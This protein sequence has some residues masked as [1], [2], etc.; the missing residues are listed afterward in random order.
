MDTPAQRSSSARRVPALLGAVALVLL[1]SPPLPDSGS[2]RDDVARASERIAPSIDEASESLARLP[3][4]F[5]QNRGQWNDAVTFRAVHGPMTSWFGGNGWTVSLTE[6]VAGTSGEDARGVAVRMAFENGSARPPS[7]LARRLEQQSFH[8]ASGSVANAATYDRLQYQDM[9]PGVDVVVRTQDGHLE[10]DVC[11]QPGAELDDVIVRC[12]GAE[13]LSVGEDGALL[14]Q[15]ALGP[16]RSEPPLTWETLPDGE[17]R[18]LAANY[19]RLDEERFGF[20]VPGWDASLPLVI[21]P[22]LSWATYLGSSS[23]DFVQAVACD[24]NGNVVVAGYT[25]N[26]SFPSTVGVFDATHNGSRD[27]FISCLTADGTTLLAST[28]LGGNKDEEARAVALD[29]SGGVVVAGWTNSVNY[30]SS[31]GA[32]ASTYAGGLGTLRSDAFVSRLDASLST[33]VFSTYLGSE[34][35]DFASAVAVDEDDTVLVAGKTSSP[36]WPTTVGAY[37]RTYNGG[38]IEVGDSFV[39]RLSPDGGTMLWSTLLGGGI[40]EYAQAMSIAPDGAVTL[41]GWTSSADFPTTAG[42]LGPSLSGTSDGFVA[43]LSSDGSSLLRATFLGGSFDE[44]ATAMQIESDGTINVA[45]TTLSPNFPVTVDAVQSAYAGG[46]FYGDGFVA[47]LDDALTT[48][49]WASFLGGSSDDFL[50]GLRVH[51]SGAILLSGWTNSSDLPVSNDADDNTL[52]GTTDAFVACLEPSTSSLVFSTYIGGPAPDKAHAVGLAING[53]VLLGGGTSSS[54]FPVTTGSYD[55]DFSGWE[56]I[57]SDAFVASFDLG[58]TPAGSIDAWQDVGY[59]LAGTAGKLPEFT[60]T[61]DLTPLSVGVATVADCLPNQPALVMVGTVAAMVPV[62][63]GTLVPFP[64][65]GI[66]A[67]TTDGV[68]GITMPYQWPGYVPSGTTLYAQTWVLD[69]AGPEGWAATN[70]LEAVSP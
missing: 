37:D 56:G 12:E 3:S 34:R 51:D 5:V 7:G 16:V 58:I 53:R 30:P 68:G 31:P 27:V 43:T 4:S 63:G 35:D 69:P 44:N 62:K 61:G 18:L 39:M 11:L 60:A 9:Y 33:L 65:F 42:V 14:M 17:R 46:G 50:T 25:L 47:R 23:L 67:T 8:A 2:V 15:T 20:S 1:A 66:L 48:V 29:G 26:S 38:S 52:G 45:G 19:V 21:D 59:S 49:E 22:G 40:D 10:Y 41:A 70:A 13:G 32:L 36:G 54:A 55:T 57:L 64:L 28:F 6:P 24:E